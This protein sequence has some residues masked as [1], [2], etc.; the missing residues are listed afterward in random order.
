MPR[1]PQSNVEARPPDW[2]TETIG[3]EIVVIGSFIQGSAENTALPIDVMGGE[4]L[5]ERGT[6][7]F[8]DLLEALPSSSG[9]LG[10]T[11]QSEVRSSGSEGSGSINSELSARK[12]RW[13]C[14][15]AV[16]WGSTRYPRR[17][18]M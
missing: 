9:V 2:V 16:G 3:Q 5:A 17:A 11:N 10:D 7:S 14:S 15:M 1:E 4:K 12:G 6:R 13:C 18:V 8:L